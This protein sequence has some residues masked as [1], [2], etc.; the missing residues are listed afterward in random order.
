MTVHRGYLLQPTYRTI[1]G[2][3]M[4]HV[5]GVTDRGE[6]FLV[7]EDRFR[8]YFFVPERGAEVV[9]RLAPEA[10]LGEPEGLRD[11]LGLPVLRVSLR[12]PGDVAPLCARLEDA[13]VECFEADIRYP[14]RYLMDHGVR[15]TFEI[16]G[17]A[18]EGRWTDLVFRRP[19]IRP[20]SFTPELRVLSLDLETDGLGREIYAAALAG[21]GEEEVL[22]CSDRAVAGA[23]VVEDEAALLARLEARIRE[24]DPD[25]L[26]GWNV[27]DFDLRVLAARA[28]A[29]GRA[30]RIGRADEP[31]RVREGSGFARGERAV[32]TGRQ[33][34]DG[35]EAVR[36][37]GLKLPDLRLETVAQAVVGRGKTIA[38]DGAR[39]V[40]EIERAFRE[41]PEELAAYNLED[42]RLVLEILDATGA[43]NLARER[44]LLSGMPLERVGA[45]IASL[46]LLLLP[47]VRK[48]G[49][50]APSVR[51][52]P[53]AGAIMGGAVLD[54]QP[55][56]FDWILVLDFK[57]L[58]PTIIR[59]FSVDPVA[60]RGVGEVR[61]G[62]I[63]APNGA[64]FEPD[65]AVLPQLLTELGAR[66]DRAKADGD[67]PL[68]L[69]VKLLM[70]SFYGV[71]GATSCRFFSAP[72]ANAITSFGQYILGLARGYIEE[73]GLR[74]L[75]GDTDSLFVASGAASADE[76]WEIGRRAAAEVNAR[77]SDWVRD[78]HGVD[79]RLELEFEKVYRRFFQPSLRGS[80]E[81][82]KKRY[83]GLRRHEDG[84][85]TLELVG[86]ESV[87]RDF[88][89]T[90][91]EFQTELIRRTLAGEEVEEFV[92]A[93]VRSVRAGDKDAGLV[94]RKA[95]RKSLSSYTATTPPHVAA[96]RK[97]ETP[98]DRRISYVITATTGPEPVIP[99]EP[100]PG[101]LD[102]NHYIK[103]ILKPVAEAVLA[104]LDIDFEDLAG[105]ERQLGL[106]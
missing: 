11:L 27:V 18:T 35:M 16:E 86:M 6:S 3:V 66:R 91:K 7:V 98:P 47:A 55:G 12:D 33:I 42:A 96:A 62:V 82:S 20:A 102:H 29:H 59:T 48:R 54:S 94:Y 40:E 83:A 103:T 74:V 36:G 72:V 87:R 81:G 106:F 39:K 65:A 92:R 99:G 10:E 22:L 25:V 44:S 37:V 69:A 60:F 31:L 57:S 15:G 104:H 63:R 75:Y 79:S 13:S 58:Y 2:T 105:G 34:L 17:E 49:I 89:E 77:V 53:E 84:T 43:L 70:N 61:P 68:S 38:F 73:H 100:L 90:G 71:L 85:E 19:E 8:P 88:P 78:E 14:Y 21:C 76:A 52:Q 51:P 32:V 28:E 1:R 56:I 46:D 64:L 101:P 9:R 26:T 93:F 95:L 45:S 23:T 80:R 4:I 97:L 41:R 50:V 67:I 5:F 24:L 30:L